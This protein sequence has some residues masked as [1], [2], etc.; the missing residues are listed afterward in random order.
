[1]TLDEVLIDVI[2]RHKKVGELQAKRILNKSIYK[3]DNTLNECIM[4]ELEALK[5]QE[6]TMKKRMKLISKV[7]NEELAKENIPIRV[8]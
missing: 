8:K 1:M 4:A 5:E 6:K 7:A 3:G 2:K